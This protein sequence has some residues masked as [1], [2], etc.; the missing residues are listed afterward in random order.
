MAI[1][2]ALSEDTTSAAL[3]TK[4]H[5][6]EHC[7]ID[8]GSLDV[9]GSAVARQVLIGRRPSTWRSTRSPSTS[10]RRAGLRTSGTGGLARLEDPTGEPPR[11]ARGDGGDPSSPV[12]THKHRCG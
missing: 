10:T 12:A 4:A 11:R 9:L 5:A 2:T 6:P 8:R 1:R 7:A 3:N